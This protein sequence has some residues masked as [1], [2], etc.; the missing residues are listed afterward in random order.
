MQKVGGRSTIA[1][2]AVTSQFVILPKMPEPDS[3]VPVQ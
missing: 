3:D 2:S 1:D